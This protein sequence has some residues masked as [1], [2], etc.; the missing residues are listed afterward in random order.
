MVQRRIDG[1]GFV[2]IARELNERGVISARHGV[3]RKG[4]EHPGTWA[5]TSVRKLLTSPRLLGQVVEMKGAAG[6]RGTPDYKRGGIVTVRRDKEGQ[7]ITFTD[8]PLIDQD[9]WDLLQAAIKTGSR[10]RGLPQ[11][12]HMLYRVLFCRNC[13]PKPFSTETAVLMYGA[14]R[15]TGRWV[16]YAYY[17]CSQCGLK[18]RLDKIEPVIERFVLHVAGPRVLLEKRIKPGDDHAAD[19]SRL[20]RRAERRR[21]L[22]DDDPDDEGVRESLAKIEGE[23]A[24]LRAAPHEPDDVQWKAVEPP[25]TV[26]QHWENLDT[27]GRGKFLRDWDVAAL[28][29]RQGMYVHMGSLEAYK[30]TFKLV[31]NRMVP[32]ALPVLISHAREWQKV[33]G[34]MLPAIVAQQISKDK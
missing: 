21:Q 29:D 6:V 11:S 32:A 28:V 30:D 26:A 22:L 10:E 12:R 7:P 18:V 1:K 13:S 3:S 5:G 16:K 14:Q 31:A 27:T 23:L 2:A 34:A 9:T 24:E 20:E 19:I 17:T 4:N 15:H 8:D 33:D 25:I